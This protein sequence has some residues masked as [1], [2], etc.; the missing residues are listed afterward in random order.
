MDR[1][2]GGQRKP[3]EKGTQQPV[4]SHRDRQGVHGPTNERAMKERAQEE[5]RRRRALEQDGTDA[6]CSRRSPRCRER[7]EKRL[8]AIVSHAPAYAEDV[9]RDA[10]V[11]QG[12]QGRLLLS[13]RGEVQVEVRDARFQRRGEPRQRRHVADLLRADGGRPRPEKE[14]RA[15]E[16]S[17]GSRMRPRAHRPF[18]ISFPG[19][20]ARGSRLVSIRAC[21]RVP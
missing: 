8:H 15:R 12:R 7:A 11:C 1:G 9:V 5:K 4:K 3:A 19:S 16:E 6:T 10:R 13:K 2:T 20:Y 14:G 21:R 17:G 18:R